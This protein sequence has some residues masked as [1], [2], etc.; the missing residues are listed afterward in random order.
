MS[1]DASHPPLPETMRCI[2]ITQPGGPEVL[3]LTKRPLRM[4]GRGEVLIKV[5]WAGVNRPD[6][7][8]RQGS[9]P[10]PPGASDI[11]GLEVSGTIVAIGPEER[12]DAPENEMPDRPPQVGDVVC[13]LLTGG[14]YADYAVADAALCLPLPPGFDLERSAALP[15][16]FFT[17]WH[18]VFERANLQAGERFLVHGGSGG[19]GTTAIQ[20]AKAFGAEVFTTAGSEEKCAK[21]VELGADRAINYK[22]EDFVAVIKEE[23]E[24]KGVNVILDMVGGDYIERNIKALAPDGRLVHIA[25]LQGSKVSLNLMPVMLKRLVVTGSTLRPQSVANKARIARA[26]KA[27]VWPLLSNGSM[28]PVID[29]TFALEDATQAHSLMEASTHIGK[30]LLKP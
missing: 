12:A 29:Q 6:V 17:V 2:E 7:I 5:E 4:P 1:D 27:Q 20:L 9:Y 3:S 26:L 28:A 21:C 10:P 25:F 8:Q 13:A 18:N 19:I 15:E 22:T 23:V 30:I 14:G 11:P 24:G 16:T